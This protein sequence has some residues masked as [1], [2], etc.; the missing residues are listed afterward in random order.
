VFTA[1]R[2]MK[3]NSNTSALYSAPHT[4][5]LRLGKYNQ[6]PVNLNFEVRTARAFA[7]EH[8]PQASNDRC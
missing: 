3:G 5:Q 8:F 7:T 6:S 2:M 1:G 4:M